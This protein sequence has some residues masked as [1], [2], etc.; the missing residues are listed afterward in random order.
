MAADLYIHI[1]EGLTEDEVK[2]FFCNDMGSK[3]FD[4]D[5]VELKHKLFNSEINNKFADTLMV[6]VGSD[7]S[8]DNGLVSLIENFIGEDF[9]V[10]THDLIFGINHILNSKLEYYRL[11]P[12]RGEITDFLYKHLGKKCFCVNW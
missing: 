2:L 7:S 11:N 10:I 3:Y 8:I 6:Y 9:P 12:D 4:L 1:L 5:K